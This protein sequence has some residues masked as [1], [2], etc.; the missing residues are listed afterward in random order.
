MAARA[1]AFEK[2]LGWGF[3]DFLLNAAIPQLMINTVIHSEMVLGQKIIEV[4]CIIVLLFLSA[5]TE[6]FNEHAN[7]LAAQTFAALD[8]N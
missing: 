7:Q 2:A 1:E 6:T 4:L 8:A 5:V 3:S